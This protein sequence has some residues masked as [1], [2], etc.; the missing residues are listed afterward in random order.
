MA[1]TG[2]TWKIGQ[3]AGLTGLTVRTLHHYDRIGLLRP[4]ARTPSGHRIYNE[5]DVRRLYAVITLRSVRMPLE[6]IALLLHGEP[7]IVGLLHD[8]VA[9]IDR[10]MAAMRALRSRLSLLVWSAEEKGVPGAP[11]LLDLIEQVNTTEQA[12]SGYF[13]D[14]QLASLARRR[15]IIGDRPMNDAMAEWP[16]LIAEV[17]ARM[18]ANTDPSDPRVQELA[19]RWTRLVEMFDGGD[20][21]LRDSLYRM[22]DDHDQEIRQG[23]GPGTEMIDYIKRACAAASGT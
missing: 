18:D 12:F 15:D 19:R 2:T 10:Q 8:H 13:S 21:G 1:E 11:D 9:H 17:Q 4:S 22:R 6:S 5:H 7:D 23:G 14:E 16:K 20:P 3:L